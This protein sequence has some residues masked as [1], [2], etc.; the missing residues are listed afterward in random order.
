M[1][2]VGIDGRSSVETGGEVGVAE[3]D[4]V[5]LPGQGCFEQGQVG[6]TEGTEAGDASPAC[7]VG[8]AQGVESSD[9]FA[10]QWCCRDGVEVALV[11]GHADLEAAPQVADAFAHGTPPPR[12]GSVGVSDDAQDLE[13]ARIVDD[14]LD[15]QDG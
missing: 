13:L 1:S 4:D 9:A 7:G 5:V 3:P 14:R 11:G 15:S 10:F 6:G 12:A 8:P 2:L